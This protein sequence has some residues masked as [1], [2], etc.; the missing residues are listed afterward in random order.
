MLL[1]QHEKEDVVQP[2]HKGKE[3]QDHSVIRQTPPHYTLHSQ[4]QGRPGEASII[5]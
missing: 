4:E 3:K 5:P 2:D 1:K